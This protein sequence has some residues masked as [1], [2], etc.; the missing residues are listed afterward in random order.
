MKAQDDNPG[1]RGDGQHH[2]NCLRP[3]SFLTTHLALLLL[4][5]QFFAGLLHFF[6]RRAFFM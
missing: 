3:D 6:G 5:S 2:L 1:Y 4:V